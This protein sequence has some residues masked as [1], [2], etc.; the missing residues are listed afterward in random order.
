MRSLEVTSWTANVKANATATEA[1]QPRM[2]EIRKPVV[3]VT[4]QQNFINADLDRWLSGEQTLALSY[5]LQSRRPEICVSF[6][7][8]PSVAWA[9]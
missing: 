7:L 4:L 9:L 1:E 2:A 5:P 3:P 8:R 6:C